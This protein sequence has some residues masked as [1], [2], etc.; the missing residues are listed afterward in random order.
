M[1]FLL[2]YVLLEDV[3]VKIGFF[4]SMRVP[5]S[6]LLGMC[7]FLCFPEYVSDCVSVCVTVCQ[8]HYV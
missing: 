4:D 8:L 1:C 5:M 6:S 7:G 2:D 3:H